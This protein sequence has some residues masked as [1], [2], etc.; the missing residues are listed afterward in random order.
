ML[1]ICDPP[2]NFFETGTEE[3][4]QT[5]Q[6]KPK[7]WRKP[8]LLIKLLVLFNYSPTR[9]RNI[10]LLLKSS[11]S[12]D[13]DNCNTCVNLQRHFLSLSKISIN[14]IRK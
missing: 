10:L 13:W 3:N 12:Y 1:N 2:T 9:R 6:R 7:H 8:V 14:V 11:S 5:C 4:L